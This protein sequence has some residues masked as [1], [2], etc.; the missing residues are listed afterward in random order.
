MRWA[1][2][3]TGQGKAA[4][5]NSSSNNNFNSFGNITGA[6]TNLSK[7]NNKSISDTSTAKVNGIIHDHLVINSNKTNDL[8]TSKAINMA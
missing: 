7:I 6:S 4:M 1:L 2:T 8:N 5:D 3:R